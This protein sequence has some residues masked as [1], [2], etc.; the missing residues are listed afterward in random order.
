MNQFAK[1]REKNGMSQE[2]VAKRL[3]IDR[4]AIAKWETGE[5]MPRVERLIQLSRLYGCTIDE[6]LGIA[7]TKSDNVDAFEEEKK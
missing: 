1:M 6:L 2:V 5:A 4:S 3:G 7:D